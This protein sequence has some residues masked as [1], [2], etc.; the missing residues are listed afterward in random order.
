MSSTSRRQK[1][2]HESASILRLGLPV[3]AANLLQISMTFTDTVMAG[4]ISPTHLAALAIA[5]SLWHPILLFAL[6][7]LTTL[8]PI[9][10]QLH[11]EGKNESMGE[12]VLQGF[13]LSAALCVP[14]IVLL[15]NLEPIMSLIGYESEV[16]RISTGYLKAISTAL[17]GILLYSVLQH[18]NEGIVLTRP[19][20]YFHVV[21]LGLNIL[22][23]YTFMFGHFGFPAMGAVGAGW[24][25]SLVWN[26]MAVVMLVFCLR[27]PRFRKYHLL[28]RFQWPSIS[29]LREI[30]QI[31][32][33]TGFAT[34]AETGLFAIV[35]LMVGML[36]VT[37]MAAHSV[38]VNIAS[39]SFMIPWGLSTAITT[40][41]GFTIGRGE[42]EKA[43][44]IGFSG[45]LLC[46][47]V[48]F[49]MAIVMAAIPET[50]I[51]IYTDNSAVTTVAVQLLF[52]AALFQLSDGLQV[53][54]LGA[55]RGLKDTRV[56]M[57][58]SLFSYS[59][60]GLPI[61]YLL[62]L[63]WGYGVIGLWTGM[64]VGLTVAAFLHNLRFHQ[65]TRRM[66][67]PLATLNL[68][69]S[70]EQ[71]HTAAMLKTTNEDAITDRL[72]L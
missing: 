2:L 23:N 53:G 51:S 70:A 66:N 43:R 65:L 1:F 49:G 58:V 71:K 56:P 24:A 50:L 69:A 10:A 32:L 35:A 60:L 6:G 40:R 7:I 38:A 36:G 68:P 17:P 39:I 57:L 9:V 18:F 27:F 34:M 3:V 48:M 33:P 15:H 20:M 59:V 12:Y 29:H 11:G 19:N 45:V 55:L 14:A 8:V 16:I 64:I 67:A 37:S 4:Q 44:R 72:S 21:G 41:V 47:I 26:A 31:G 54:A 52:M 28:Q 5:S 13:W 46:G 61:A 42:P 30:L 22:G 25:S 63:Q 62:G